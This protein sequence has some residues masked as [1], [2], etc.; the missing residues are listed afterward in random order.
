[1]TVRLDDVAAQATAHSLE[2]TL[3]ELEGEPDSR[4]RSL[5]MDAIDALMLLYGEG[6]ARVVVAHRDG[7]GRVDDVLNGKDD[8]VT[9]LLAIHD[10]LPRS[11]HPPSLVRLAR[12][13]DPAEEDEKT[14]FRGDEHADEKCQLCSAP[15]PSDHRHLIDIERR[16]I[17][18]AC[19]A[20]AILFDGRAA[21]GGRYRLAPRRYRSLDGSLLDGGLWERLELPVD[22]I[23][24]FFSSTA[25]RPVAFY[26]GPMGTTESS[27]PL[28]AWQE[29]AARSPVL[30]TLEPDVEAVLVR[31]TR[32]ARDYWIVPVDECYR[33]AGAM[34]VT[35]QGISGG[36]AMR[37]TVDAFF[38]RLNR[39]DENRGTQSINKSAPAEATWSTTRGKW[40]TT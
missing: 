31:R 36:D 30:E 37:D 25:N 34:R 5:A 14:L 33:L 20:C 32:G 1:M 6:L 35:W 24:M 38:R 2:E 29:I 16:E 26:P 40:A 9:Q 27:L 4:A 7:P 13:R 15:I 12:R 17:A 11:A 8:V 19:A 22:V 28:P 21:A 18:C 10:L 39:R 23:F 3:A